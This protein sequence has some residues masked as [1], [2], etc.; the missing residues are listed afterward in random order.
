MNLLIKNGFWAVIGLRI[1]AKI[2]IE[3]QLGRKR[4]QHVGDRKLE[5]YQDQVL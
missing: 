5:V 3:K 1:K 4:L 2:K